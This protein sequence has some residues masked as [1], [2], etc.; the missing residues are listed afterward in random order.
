M[1]ILYSTRI[2]GWLTRNGTYISAIDKALKVPYDEALQIV[3]KHYD[4][5]EGGFAIVPVSLS[6]L[7]QA[8]A[9]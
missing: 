4:P 5:I 7:E 8:K 9:L 3:A 6:A 2:G 1:F